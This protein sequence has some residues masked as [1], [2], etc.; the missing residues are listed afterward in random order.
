M[1]ISVFCFEWE[2]MLIEWLQ[3]HISSGAINII[4]F[5][6]LFGEEKMMVLILGFLYW[7]FDKRLGK[8]VGLNMLVAN[9]WNPLIKNIVHRARPYY[10]NDRVKLLRKI[11][12]SADETDI[13]AQGFSFP[14]GHSASAV[15][16]YGS[17]ALYLKKNW[18]RILAIV[19]PLLV[20]FSRVVVGAHFPT[21]VFAGWIL[22]LLIL[23]VIPILEKKIN[24]HWLFY[25]LLLATGI[26]GFFYCQSTD[27]YTAYGMLFGFAFAVWFEEKFVNFENTRNPIRMI[28]RVL[29]G[30]AA[31]FALNTLL[32]LPFPSE[33]LASA[34]TGAFVI[35]TI[36]YAI[37]MFFV[38]AIYPILFKWTAKIGKGKKKDLNGNA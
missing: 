4:S 3:T 36:R 19:L 18:L 14:S 17:I 31:Y 34:T 2:L 28:L 9:L 10:N 27:F 15:T 38:M 12:S 23:I 7:S 29:G 25:G 35:R 24:N 30:G 32:K 16:V 20:G 22:G 11:D 33:F 37:V 26:P 6:S 8:F 13:A 21:D 1:A 5:F